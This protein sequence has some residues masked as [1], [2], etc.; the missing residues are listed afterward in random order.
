MEIEAALIANDKA[1]LTPE[2]RRSVP[3]LK[4]LLSEDFREIGATGA[5]FG[6]Q[7]VL[8][9]LPKTDNWSATAQD[10]ECRMLSPTVG[11]VVFRCVITHDAD[12]E[13]VYSHRSSIWKLEDG[14]WKMV[15]HQ[16]TK[17][18]PFEVAP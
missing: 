1:L 16:G 7:N 13:P 4:S 17:V 11:Q 5:Y 8:D 14:D 10:F 15:F 12:V 3:K 2:V 18:A 6:L 9:R